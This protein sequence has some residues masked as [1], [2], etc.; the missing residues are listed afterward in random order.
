MNFNKLLITISAILVLT[1]TAFSADGSLDT[2]FN[3]ALVPATGQSIVV[4]NQ[5]IVQKDGKILVAGSFSAVGGTSRVGIARLNADGSLDTGFNPGTGASDSN[6]DSVAVQADGKIVVAGTFTSF[7]GA[8]RQRIAR[9]NADGSL[10]TTFVPDASATN[11]VNALAIQ[12]DG[13]ILIGVAGSTIKRL[14]AEGKLDNTFNTTMVPQVGVIE[15]KLQADGRILIGGGWDFLNSAQYRFG[16]ARLNADGSTDS[17]FVPHENNFSLY[18]AAVAEIIPQADGKTVA[19]GNLRINST[20]NNKHIVRFNADGTIDSTFDSGADTN[21]TI[22]TVLRQP[23]GKYVIGGSFTAYNGTVVNRLAR[24]NAN[25]TIDNT[26]NANVNNNTIYTSARA[27]NGKILI[28]GYFTQVDSTERTGLAQLRNAA[29]QKASICDYDGDGRTD[30]A[31]RRVVSS[32]FNWYIAASGGGAPVY[33]QF[34]RGG[35]RILCGDY[36]GDNKTDSTLR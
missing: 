25:G 6:I 21:N 33:T 20:V 29:P 23:N 8:A 4:I 11:R 9:L 30:F 1:M 5:T 10:D 31:L 17:S 27:A 24:L 34:G 12:P 28:A 7:N 32:Q 22:F 18:G 3:Q 36:D 15:I 13:K 19:V 26:F 35:D 14:T 16:L 2:T